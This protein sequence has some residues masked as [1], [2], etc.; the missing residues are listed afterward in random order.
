MLISS[1][2]YIHHPNIQEIAK[3]A[4]L[5]FVQAKKFGSGLDF[6]KNVESFM[7]PKEY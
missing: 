3:V 1:I 6:M 4:T 2:D 5:A 7:D